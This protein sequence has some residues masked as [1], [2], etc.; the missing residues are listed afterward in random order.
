MAPPA[1]ID[2]LPGFISPE[3]HR[4]L[5][6][7][8]PTSFSEIPPVL[9][10]KEENVAVSFDPPLAGLLSED[11]ALGTLYI[12]ESALVFM[13]VSGRGF[14]VDYP[15]ITLHAISRAESGP[16][17]YC[18]LD[19]AVDLNNDV[20]LEDDN[21]DTE[22]RELFIVPQEQNNLETIFENL[23]YCAS[24]HPDSTSLSDADED[25]FIDVDES[26]LETFSGNETEEFSEVGR[27]RSD[28]INNSR[29][30]PY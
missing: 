29:F 30:A 24:L 2:T 12:V 18:Q 6:S 16:S 23:S 11:C 1:L 15:S 14:S 22:M 9:R 8:T 20:S 13:S 21:V 26:N 27:V 3:E 4:T 19:E 25:A 10:H 28:F 17:L 7:A 5:V